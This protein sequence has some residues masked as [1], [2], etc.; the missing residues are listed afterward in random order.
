[1]GDEQKGGMISLGSQ[2]GELDYCAE[3]ATLGK[4]RGK[5]GSRETR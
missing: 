3:N 5:G 4:R 1:M 2:M